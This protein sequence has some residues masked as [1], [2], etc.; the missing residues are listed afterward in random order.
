M[1]SFQEYITESKK[2]YPFTV[3]LCG[4]LPESA[5]KVMKTAMHKFVVNKLSKNKTTPIQAT[6]FDFPGEANAE[7]H[8]FELDLQYPTTSA[9]LTELIADNLK[10]S[11]NR[12]RVRT[13]GEMAE[14]ALNLE[15]MD[16]KKNEAVLTKD[17]EAGSE[18]QKRVGQV[19]VGSFLK[20]L[21][22][23][24]AELEQVKGTNEQLLAKSAHKETSESFEEPKPGVSP[25]GSK[26]N[27]IPDPKKGR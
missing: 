10:I 18:G 14:L 21:G 15:H 5:D 4:A 24:K 12:I 17:Y 9:V 3:K 23:A 11:P 25:V 2:T 6:Q 27:K 8:V 26:Q 13:P 19:H 1:K 16:S 22:T 20:E 7:V